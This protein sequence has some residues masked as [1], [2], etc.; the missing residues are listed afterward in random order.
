MVEV[1][2]IGLWHA[3]YPLH[4]ALLKLYAYPADGTDRL[5]VY[6]FYIVTMR[7]NSCS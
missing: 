2:L 6:A 3:E 4:L 1:L 7:F 5:I